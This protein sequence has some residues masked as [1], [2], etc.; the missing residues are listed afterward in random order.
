MKTARNISTLCLIFALVF[1]GCGKSDEEVQKVAALESEFSQLQMQYQAQMPE[2]NKVAWQIDS[3][4][5]C[6]DKT[7]QNMTNDIKAAQVLVTEAYKPC[8]GDFR[9]TFQMKFEELPKA[10]EENI[11][12]LKCLIE[13]AANAISK[14]H[15]V[16]AACY[17]QEAQKKK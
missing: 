7:V 13:K 17:K 10:L 14:S 11:S 8:E 3:L 4:M 2:L 16:I 15:E 12:V 6:K 9:P 5:K 1:S